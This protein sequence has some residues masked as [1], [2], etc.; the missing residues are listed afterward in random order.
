MRPADRTSQFTV[1]LPDGGESRLIATSDLG[2]KPRSIVVV[3]A[4]LVS[5]VSQSRS[6]RAGPTRRSPQVQARPRRSTE[7]A[8]WYADP[9]MRNSLFTWYDGWCR[10]ST[11]SC[12]RSLHVMPAQ[13]RQPARRAPGEQTKRRRPARIR[14]SRR[15]AIMQLVHGHMLR[16]ANDRTSVRFISI[17]RR[18]GADNVSAMPPKPTTTG[19]PGSDVAGVVNYWRSYTTRHQRSMFHYHDVN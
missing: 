18:E 1:G 16:G 17:G 3:V 4:R 11:G 12:Q 8:A 6:R 13:R 10:L 19:Q 14:Q 7:P 15:V 9:Q 2:L 5:G